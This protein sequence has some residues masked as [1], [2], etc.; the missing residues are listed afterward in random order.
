MAESAARLVRSAPH[1]AVL[2]AALIPTRSRKLISS[3]TGSIG[4]PGRPILSSG[5]GRKNFDG[6]RKGHLCFVAVDRVAEVVFVFSCL[7][8]HKPRR[9][10]PRAARLISQIF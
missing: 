8:E 3:F 9:R 5:S 6:C 2:T 10:I 1:P 7:A 4:V